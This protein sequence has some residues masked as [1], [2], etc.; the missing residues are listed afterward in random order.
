MKINQEAL[1]R[2]IGQH[3]PKLVA[4]ITYHVWDIADELEVAK[5]GRSKSAEAQT[6]IERRFLSAIADQVEKLEHK[7]HQADLD[8]EAL[9]PQES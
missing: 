8:V 7:I 5:M 3:M 2:A 6:E 1:D 9:A 4:Q